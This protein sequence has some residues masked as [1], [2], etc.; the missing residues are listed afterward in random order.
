M[1][2]FVKT[3]ILD[4]PWRSILLFGFLFALLAEGLSLLTEYRSMGDNLPEGLSKKL[5]VW[6]LAG[7]FAKYTTW[8]AQGYLERRNKRWSDGRKDAGNN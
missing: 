4:A 1:T 5:V 8:R 3:Y 7:I 6:F 2:P